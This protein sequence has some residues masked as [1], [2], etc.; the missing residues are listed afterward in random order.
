MAQGIVVF[1]TAASEE[2]AAQIA[3]VLVKEKL[4]ACCNIIP[5][6]TSVFR[7]KDEVC[8]EKEFLLIAKTTQERFDA[9]SKRVQELHSYDVPEIIALPIEAGSA[10]YMKWLKDQVD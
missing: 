3:D 10:P 8:R 6:V 1:I 7:W 9:L 2:E 4:A 5:G